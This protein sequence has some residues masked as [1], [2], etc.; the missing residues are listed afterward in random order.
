L[1]EGLNQYRIKG[2]TMSTVKLKNNQYIIA[3]LFA[4]IATT[5]GG[6]FVFTHTAVALTA[7]ERAELEAQ[8][9]KLEEEIKRQ[10]DILL[11]Q[12]GQSVST[13]ILSNGVFLITSSKFNL[14]I[15][16]LKPK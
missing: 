6:F 11:K 15:I 5:F 4:L 10:E 3:I 7:S 8:L 12:K 2:Y 16:P 14:K 9:V 1:K 13:K